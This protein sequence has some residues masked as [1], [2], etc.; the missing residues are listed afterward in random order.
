MLPMTAQPLP[1]GSDVV[2]QLGAYVTLDELAAVARCHVAT[3]RRAIAAGELTA[4]RPGRSYLVDVEEAR[5]WLR[6][7]CFAQGDTAE[8]AA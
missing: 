2:A 7:R 1:V 3:L 4:S 8:G 6:S 5:R